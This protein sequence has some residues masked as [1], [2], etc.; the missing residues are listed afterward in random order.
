MRRIVA[1][2]IVCTFAALFGTSEASAQL[3]SGFG[4]GT[5]LIQSRAAFGATGIRGR[6]GRPGLPYFAQFPPV[7]YSGI[8]R[9]PYGISPFA[10]PAGIRPVELDVAPVKVDPATIVNPYFNGLQN[11]DVEEVPAVQGSGNKSASVVKNPF[12]NNVPESSGIT[13]QASFDA[14]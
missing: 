12:F 14:N 9:R 7:Y 5:G 8:V 13:R 6:G 4:F 1:A 10:A 2:A 3:Q 11:A